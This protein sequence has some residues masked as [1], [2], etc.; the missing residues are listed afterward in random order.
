[1]LGIQAV[2]N[3]P[4]RDDPGG[5]GAEIIEEVRVCPACYDHGSVFHE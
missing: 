4:S 1:M 5:K 2:H 3:L